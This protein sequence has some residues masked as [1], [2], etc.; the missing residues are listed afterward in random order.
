[1]KT[2][3]EWLRKDGDNNYYVARMVDAETIAAIQQ[4]ARA[5][6]AEALLAAI[7]G[8]EGYASL[9]ESDYETSSNRNPAKD[10]NKNIANARAALKEIT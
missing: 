7:D 3:A 5:E 6:L 4:D 2:A 8:L 10:I 9:V 1:M